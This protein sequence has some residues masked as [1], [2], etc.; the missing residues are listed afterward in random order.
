MFLKI[1][2]NRKNL[3]KES[4]L[5]SYLFT[6]TYHNICRLFRNRKIHEK[7]KENFG[8]ACSRAIS[9]EEQLE[10]RSD[11]EQVD[12]LIDT[13]PGNQRTIF[14]KSRRE[15]KSSKEIALEMNLSPGTVDNQISLAL[16]YLR[17]QIAAYNFVILLFFSIFF[18]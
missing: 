8:I 7:Y 13:L 5:K 17:K 11:L 9:P 12:R 2:E 10:Y 14:N 15:G 1:W 18:D 6:I 4:S 16:K 3:I